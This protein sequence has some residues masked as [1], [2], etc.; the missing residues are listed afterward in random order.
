MVLFDGRMFS[1]QWYV[2]QLARDNA[3]YR[4]SGALFR[5]D[6]PRPLRQPATLVRAQFQG[7]L[8][9]FPRR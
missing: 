2:F 4:A 5:G 6:P 7:S 9:L 8:V 3:I 1:F